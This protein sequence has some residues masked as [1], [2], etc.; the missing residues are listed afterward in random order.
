MPFGGNNNQDT[1][2]AIIIRGGTVYAWS[3]VGSPEEG[4]D[5]DFAPLVVEG[6]N[7]FSVG[8]GMGE[9]PSVPTNDTAKQPTVLFI[10]LNISKNE[11]VTISDADGK[12]IKEV[13][14]P[15][16]MRRSASLVTTPEFKLGAS[17]TVKTKGYEKTFTINEPFT[18]VR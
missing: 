3:E 17:Y 13:T 16:N 5:C 6:G 10:G 8:G 18:A 11:P 4:I 7:V 9:M 15:F 14:I 2:P 12:L 1:T